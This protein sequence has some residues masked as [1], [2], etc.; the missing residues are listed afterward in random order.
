MRRGVSTVAGAMSK[1]VKHDADACGILLSPNVRVVPDVDMAVFWLD[2]G[3]PWKD[4]PRLEYDE[5]SPKKCNLA[6]TFT[7][8]PATPPILRVEG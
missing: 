6:H 3:K 5:L 1:T 4:S 2:V 7:V 8:R